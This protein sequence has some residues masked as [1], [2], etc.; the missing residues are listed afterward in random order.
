MQTKEKIRVRYKIRTVILQ[1]LTTFYCG[2]GNFEFGSASWD[3]M[4]HKI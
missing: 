3:I 4:S 2:D 1:S